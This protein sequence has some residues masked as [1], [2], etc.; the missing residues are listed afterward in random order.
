MSSRAR[1]KEP[2]VP[3]ISAAAIAGLLLGGCAADLDMRGDPVTTGQAIP[4]QIRDENAIELEV[5]QSVG[6]SF[7]IAKDGDT[8]ESLAKRV[9]IDPVILARANGKLPKDIL[10]RRE[11]LIIPQG[12]EWEPSHDDVKDAVQAAG[13]PGRAAGA[14]S[15]AP[16][17]GRV[18][19]G[20][21]DR[22]LTRP[23]R[24]VE[25]DQSTSPIE[26][27]THVVRAGE[28]AFGVARTYGTS[29]RVLA[30][31]N[32]L[33]SDFAVH[34]GQT[35]IVPQSLSASRTASPPKIAA[36]HSTPLPPSA[37]QPK[38]EPM[39]EVNIPPSPALSS[40]DV[41]SDESAYL[42]PV[43]GEILKG[44]DSAPGGSDGI[45]I[46]AVEG[47]SVRAAADGTVA[48]VTEA[49]DGTTILLIRH[50]GNIYTVYANIMDVG[51]T[52]D[53]EVKRGQTVGRVAG[54]EPSYLHFEVRIGAR[55][56]DPFEFVQ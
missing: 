45:D 43:R 51:P 50:E 16:G 28:T 7:A 46:E 56:V 47:T 31:W 4:D 54:G 12:A 37:S 14:T 1:N 2:Y 52:K 29:V 41:D 49:A 24:G 25:F 38:P 42:M 13:R 44:Y 36:G 18:A 55:S 39:A 11:I 53:D 33:D 17:S 35:L 22:L 34:E 30:E 6:R 8:V 10:L 27:I 23:P 32:G 3:S 48:L 40:N 26:T 5:I 15:P 19:A 20:D 9:D 21:P